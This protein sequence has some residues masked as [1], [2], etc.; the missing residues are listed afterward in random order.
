MSFVAAEQC[1]VI[2]DTCDLASCWPANWVSLDYGLGF[3]FP[4]PCLEMGTAA[5]NSRQ[6]KKVLGL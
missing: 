1:R 5:N 3:R 4:K 2:E 6:N